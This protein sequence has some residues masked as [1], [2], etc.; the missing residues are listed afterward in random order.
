MNE[1]VIKIEPYKNIFKFLY[2]TECSVTD[3]VIN[4]LI[5]KHMVN[6]N[7][8]ELE[9]LK[10]DL[11]YLLPKTKIKFD[12]PT[13]EIN[14][15][16]DFL[17]NTNS[18]DKSDWSEKLH[19]YYN[20]W[21]NYQLRIGCSFLEYI[22][23]YFDSLYDKI[24]FY[25][26]FTYSIYTF[27][28]NNR[29]SKYNDA[30]IKFLYL[31]FKDLNNNVKFDKSDLQDIQKILSKF[32][33]EQI[34]IRDP[35]YNIVL[36][37]CSNKIDE[38]L[39]PRGCIKEMIYLDGVFYTLDELKNIRD[40]RNNCLGI[41]KQLLEDIEES[42]TKNEDKFRQ[43]VIEKNDKTQDIVKDLYDNSLQKQYN[44][45]KVVFSDNKHKWLGDNYLK[46]EI[47]C[48]IVNNITNF[49]SDVNR[50][51]SE[52]LKEL[53][54]NSALQMSFEQKIDQLMTQEYLKSDKFDSR[55]NDIKDWLEY[56]LNHD[57]KINYPNDN[58]LPI[59]IEKLNIQK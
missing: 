27:K 50:E 43:W 10:T 1:L 42:K 21:N 38:L 3:N 35:I 11:E 22:D 19:D 24:E 46:L 8:Q 56:N 49:Y 9:S 57:L 17:N 16:V 29:P 52:Y 55:L 23:N 14:N 45:S 53:Y 39:K 28:L 47:E 2:R 30:N 4:K 32:K 34:V 41:R 37:K 20:N 51:S 33:V 25:T 36:Y 58:L 15:H 18:V 26:T 44:L 54:P 5:E 7:T 40:I 31:L 13:L 6:N 12:L 48:D 59:K